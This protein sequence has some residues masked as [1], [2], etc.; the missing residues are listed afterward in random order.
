MKAG[1]PLVLVTV[2]AAG[3]AQS[4]F[5]NDPRAAV[6]GPDYLDYIE[7]YPRDRDTQYY[8]PGFTVD[9]LPNRG[10]PFAETQN[11]GPAG[12]QRLLITIPP[13]P[14]SVQNLEGKGWP[15]LEREGIPVFGRTRA[16]GQRV[17]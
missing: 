3:C 9:G 4:R 1:W 17:H 2:L 16:T 13:M 12:I 10:D 14:P 11:A 15:E 7:E 6:V 8:Y 5:Q